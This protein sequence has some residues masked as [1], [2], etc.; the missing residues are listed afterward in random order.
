VAHSNREKAWVNLPRDFNP[1]DCTVAEASSFRR[2][3]I[4]TTFRKIR[5]GIYES[6]LDGR[7]R[8]IVF[9]SVKADRDRMLA[10]SHTPPEPTG[11]RKVGRPKRPT[12]ESSVAAE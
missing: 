8:K 10:A 4:W 1:L 2:E 11:K 5:E 12:P 7:V 3:S 6:Y 9:A